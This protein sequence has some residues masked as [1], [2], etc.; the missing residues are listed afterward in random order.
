MVVLFEDQSKNLHAITPY[1]V[2]FRLITPQG[3]RGQLQAGDE[4]GRTEERHE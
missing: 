4:S 1:E 3:T 2:E